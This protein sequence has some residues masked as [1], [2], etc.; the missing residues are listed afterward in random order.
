[1]CNSIGWGFSRVKNR[2]M[3]AGLDKIVSAILPS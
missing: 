1:M 2:S 3:H